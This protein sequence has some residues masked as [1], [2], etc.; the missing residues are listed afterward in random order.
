M[1]YNTVEIYRLRSRTRH[2]IMGYRRKRRSPIRLLALP[3]LTFCATAL[4]ASLGIKD[5]ADISLAVEVQ[6]FFTFQDAPT[7]LAAP[8]AP[9]AL[10]GTETAAGAAPAEP[11]AVQAAEAVVGEAGL[12]EAVEAEAA[13]AEDLMEPTSAL[14]ATEETARGEGEA[15]FVAEGEETAALDPVASVGLIKEQVQPG[16][17]LAKMFARLNLSSN[18]LHDILASGPAAKTLTGIRPGESIEITFD[19]DGEFEEMFFQR[20]LDEGVRI[21]RNGDKLA[22]QAIQKPVEKRSSEAG[23]S[24][25]DSLYFSAKRAGLSDAMILELAAIFGYDIDFALDIREGDRFSVIFEE[26]WLEGQKLRNG[27][28]LAAEFV[29]QGQVYRAVRFEDPQG[30]ASY[31]TPEGNGMRKAFIRTPLDFLRITSKFSKERCHPILG[32]CRPHKGVDYAAPTGTPVK[33]AGNGKIVF[34]G[35]KSG[36]GNTVIIQ[37]SDNRY[38]TLYGHLSRFASSLQEGSRVKQ[39]EIIGYVGATGLATGPHLH[40]EFRVNGEHRDPLT[41][42]L[43]KSEPIEKQYRRAF[44]QQSAQLLA[45]LDTLSKTMYAAADSGGATKIR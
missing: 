28:I 35:N 10:A 13:P 38:T 6:N 22:S 39:G 3:V 23:G 24:I 41:V 37:H 2:E 11:V 16:D 45:R 40:Y 18:L 12:T 8:A 1:N 27:P 9:Q 34:R 19:A 7:D 21:W 44:K 17:S 14:A 25:S 5:V 43:P 26:D 33:A 30:H 4:Y 36:Y 31:Y 32:V 20:S 29:N 15:A 42:K